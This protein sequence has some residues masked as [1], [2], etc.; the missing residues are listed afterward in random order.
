MYIHELPYPA[1]VGVTIWPVNVSTMQSTVFLIQQTAE[2]EKLELTVTD[3]F[4]KVRQLVV[5]TLAMYLTMYVTGIST[6]KFH[7]NDL[8]GFDLF[9]T[10]QQSSL[11]LPGPSLGV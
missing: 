6:S 8:H 10:R 2:I 1:I 11:I 3:V 4:S 5:N 7:V 9:I